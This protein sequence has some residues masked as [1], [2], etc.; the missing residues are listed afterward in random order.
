MRVEFIKS[1]FWGAA[2]LVAEADFKLAK[3]KGAEFDSLAHATA[4]FANLF[5]VDYTITR[6]EYN[7]AL[8]ALEKNGAVI[9]TIGSSQYPER[10]W[11]E[12][13]VSNNNQPK[14]VL[15]ADEDGYHLIR[16]AHFNPKAVAAIQKRHKEERKK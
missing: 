2:L 5:D 4:A 7:A 11:V 9:F 12:I 15:Y 6:R 3:T 8:D 10:R 13:Q 16:H 14:R 1:E